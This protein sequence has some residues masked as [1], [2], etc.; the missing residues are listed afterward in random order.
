MPVITFQQAVTDETIYPYHLRE[1][2]KWNHQAA[3]QAFNN[4]RICQKRGDE[5]GAKK[6]RETCNRLQ[7]QSDELNKVANELEAELSKEGI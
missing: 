3:L 1:C 5:I 2:A 4:S 6:E 7:R